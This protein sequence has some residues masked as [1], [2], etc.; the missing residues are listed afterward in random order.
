MYGALQP[1]AW[2]YFVDWLAGLINVFNEA[3]AD[4]G[5]DFTPTGPDA[6]DGEGGEPDN[7]ENKGSGDK[8]D[9]EEDDGA[10]GS[11]GD[12]D[13]DGDGSDGDDDGKQDDHMIP[14]SRYDYQANRA[15]NAESEND[16]LRGEL[17]TLR[18][19]APDS[20]SKDAPTYDD[21]LSDLDKQIE[22]ARADNDIDR[23]VDLSKQQ[24][25]IERQMYEEIAA[26]SS[27]SAGEAAKE[28]IRLDA[29][30]DDLE[31]QYEFLREDSDKYDEALVGE[32]LDL[33]EGYVSSGKYTASQAM[34][35]AASV[36]I[37]AP[38]KDANAGDKRKTD[39]N[40]NLEAAGKTPPGMEDT[41][42]NSD[43]G[44]DIKGDPGQIQN[45]SLEEFDA[46]P[47][48]TKKRLRGDSI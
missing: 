38:S 27:S 33:Q 19:Q 29:I 22:K 9:G 4:R 2:D 43:K 42:E 48:E 32:I 23:V 18:G 40:K 31:D 35:R 1:T 15:R 26:N 46:L 11:G 16:K 41:G 28:Q 45:M 47:E 21:Q 3:K 12:G 39:V 34:R 36:L 6:K 7:S 37:P 24:R 20:G 13:G 5:D 44:G 17:E 14:K 25:G 30:I 10:G 8:G